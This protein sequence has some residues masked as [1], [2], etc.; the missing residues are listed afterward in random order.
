MTVLAAMTMLRRVLNYKVSVEALLELATWLAIPYL[1]VGLV[2][3]FTHPDQ[4][5]A[6]ETTLLTRVPAG[7]NLVAFG[8]VTL[9]WP[10]MIFAD[11]LCR[12]T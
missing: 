10:V 7:A 6:I 8:E 5:T 4:V 12:M 9:F 11:Q 3:T 2:W 1:A